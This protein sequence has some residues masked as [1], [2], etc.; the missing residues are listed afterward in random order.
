MGGTDKAKGGRPVLRSRPLVGGVR[1]SPHGDKDKF[2]RV[3][4]G[5]YADWKATDVA[6]KGLD[7]AGFKAFVKH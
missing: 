5:P 3:Q 2:Y 7:A 1:L 6:R 4:V